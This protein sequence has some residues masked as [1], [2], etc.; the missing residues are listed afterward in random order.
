MRPSPGT[1]VVGVDHSAGSLQAL[2]CAVEQAV[3]EHRSL[4]L[5]HAVPVT[6]PVWLDPDAAG[7]QASHERSLTQQG[8]AVLSRARRHVERLAPELSVHELFSVGDPREVLLD[9]SVNAALIV[10]GSRGRGHLRSLLLGSTAVA[11]VRHA[12]CPVIVHRPDRSSAGHHGIAVGA[13]ATADSLEVLEF[14]YRQADWHRRPLTVVHCWAFG[15]SS[16]DGTRQVS[17]SENQRRGLAESLAGLGEKYPDV[18]VLPVVE[19]GM[20]E[21][22]LMELADDMSLLV[23]GQNHGSRASQFMF[24]SVSVWLIEHAT[25]SVAVVPLTASLSTAGQRTG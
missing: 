17:T 4:T 13:D 3:R 23:V 12:S 9:L 6:T 18:V 14:P 15:Q 5:V 24:G 21:R 20:P 16:D 8:Q 7:V 11:V 10:V 2:E 22:H 25:C 19:Q 1:I